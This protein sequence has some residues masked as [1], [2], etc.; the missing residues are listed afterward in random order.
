[1][2]LRFLLVA[3]NIDV[4]LGE[5][6]LARRK[7]MLQS[8]AT[9][10]VDLGSVYDQTLRRIKERKG[11]RAR[12]GIEVLMWVSH[13][14]RP[15][16]IE[17]LCHALAVEV[18]TTDLDYENIRPPDTVLGSCLGLVMVDKE[19]ST[20]RLIHYTLQEYLSRPGILPD[21]CKVLAQS[22][23]VYL[24]YDC[25]KGLPVDKVP[26][27]GEMPLLK[28]SSFYWGSHAKIKLSDRAKALTLELLGQY[29]THIPSILLFNK[30]SDYNTSSVTRYLFTGLHCASYFGIIE[31]M[32]SLIET[33]GCNINQG[34]CTGITP[35]MLAAQWGNE[36]AVALLL[37]QDNIDPNKPHIRGFTT[38]RLL[39]S[40]MERTL[41]SSAESINF[42]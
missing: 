23:L 40:G 6:S 27:L 11:D 14:E 4:I 26:N 38:K 13:A 2:L 30:I 39:H 42:V 3:L 15:L 24:N 9:T 31:V 25:I 36:G 33:K 16:R 37:T 41:W 12:L 21:A 1:M 8:V 10:G 28:Y 20:V 18:G 19:T 22:C 35:L 7:K 29:P 17:E 32:A 34:D 5:T